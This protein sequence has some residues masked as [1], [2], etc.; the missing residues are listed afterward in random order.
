[1]RFEMRRLRIDEV[2]VLGREPVDAET[3]AAAREIV[4]RVRDDEEAV[5][6]YA[7]QLDGLTREE[8]LL[9]GRRE[10]AAALAEID[11]EDRALLERTAER[12]ESFAI[13][14]KEALEEVTI[15]VPGGHAGH[16]VTPV[17][18]A[19]CYAPG[20]RYPL[21]S[22]VLMTAVTARAAGVEEVIVASPK[23]GPITRAAAAIANADA[24]LCCGGAQAIAAMAYGRGGVPA[25]ATIVGPG[26]RW[27]TAAKQI[28]SGRISIDMLAGPSELVVLA[29]DSADPA[30]IAADLLA[31]AEHDPQAFPVLIALNEGLI[32]EVERALF[33]Q[34]ESLPTREVAEVALKNGFC[35]LAEDRAVAIE[36]CDRLAPEHLQIMTRDA[37]DW[38]ERLD[39]YGALFI[40]SHSAEVFGDYGVGPNHTLPTG[41]TA[42]S[43]GGLSVF[44]FLRIRTW[45]R[46][47]EAR[48][49]ILEDAARLAR[50]EGL[51][52]HA[53]AAERRKG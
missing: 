43:F 11:R 23:P 1:M 21:P 19:G 17:R 8:P 14:Q 29:D 49:E 53:R 16:E 18:V 38:A 44:S 39:H 22:S 32:E 50:L 30:V 2:P 3:L 47:D 7:E 25:A 6:E 48:P 40:G 13:A 51:E 36:A 52:A 34:L 41:G 33:E 12:I 5:L 20:G 28:V 37:D 15:E 42:R 26:N 10:L 27:V 45:L 24:L 31:Q 35:L 4:T 46:L 9:L